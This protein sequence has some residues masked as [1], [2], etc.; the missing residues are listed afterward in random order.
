L[1]P[2]TVEI[3]K[4]APMKAMLLSVLALVVLTGAVPRLHGQMQSGGQT[5]STPSM[6]DMSGVKAA[7]KLQAPIDGFLT[8]LNG[9][10]D[11]RASEIVFDPGGTIKEHY[12]FG[13][14]I[15]LL[16]AGELTLIDSETGQEQIVH[17]GEFFYES[18]ARRH[19]VVNRGREPARVIVVELVPAGLKGPAMVS[20]TRRRELE[21]AGAQ[22]K[23]KI[24]S[25]K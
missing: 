16:A 15:R 22:L 21:A 25:V 12:H 9:E 17:P 20:I 3:L 24:C 18:G 11:M 23:D 6:I 2:G 19:V 1:V 10:V 13:P 4:E 8:A 7:M 14:G 5:Q